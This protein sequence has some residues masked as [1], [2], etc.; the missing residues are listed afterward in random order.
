MHVVRD[1]RKG[2]GGREE[3]AVTLRPAMCVYANIYSFGHIAPCY[4]VPQYD[5]I[6]SLSIL[7]RRC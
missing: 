5:Q 2:H 7:G 1:G 6:A 3:M 4:L